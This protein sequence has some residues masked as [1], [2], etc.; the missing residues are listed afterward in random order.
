MLL[1]VN[2]IFVPRVGY[3]ACAWGG[4]AGYA[5]AMVLSYIVGQKKNPIRYPMHEMMVYVL[6]TTVLFV[7]MTL[8]NHHLP[9]WAAV[10][11]NT[12]LLVVF[13]VYLVKKDF[14]LTPIIQ[15]IKEKVKK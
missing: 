8:A 4:F 14:P 10:M 11:V 7:G 13:V 6:L 1:L 2:I 15:K 12:L 9:V 3:I 5:T